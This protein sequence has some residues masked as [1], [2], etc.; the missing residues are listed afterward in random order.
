[1]QIRKFLS[2]IFMVI[3]S[4]FAVILVLF[5]SIWLTVNTK[6][7]LDIMKTT[8]YS[9]QAIIDAENILDNY[10]P[11][12]KASVI[13][14]DTSI[15]SDITSIVMALDNNIVKQVSKTIK[16]TM[17]SKIY[18]VLEDEVEENLKNNFANSVADKYVKSIFPIAEYD[19]VSNM[20]VKYIS[21]FEFAYII[22]LTISLIIIWYLSSS[23]RSRK[24]VVV[25]L[26]NI[27]ILS[28][29]IMLCLMPFNNIFIANERISNVV[30]G[31]IKGI[32]TVI[33]IEAITIA[34][35]SVG[36][37]YL[38]YFKKSKDINNK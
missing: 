5:T 1:M 13:L 14:D 28:I 6:N 19:N 36:I 25:A 7:V 15:Q 16:D 31:I 29:C 9:Q 37:N 3:L 22:I 20:Y 26:Y 12:D 35:V 33:L 34:L 32:E 2:P 38:L 23:S 8:G 21:E 4:V 11:Q 18:S 10:L 30:Q 27:V 24:W 17:S